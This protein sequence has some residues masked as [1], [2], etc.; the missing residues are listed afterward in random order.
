MAEQE[1]ATA[2]FSNGANA[3]TG[4]IPVS[5]DA[6]RKKMTWY[7]FM[8]TAMTEAEMVR[9]PFM[10]PLQA[11]HLHCQLGKVMKKSICSQ[12]D[13]KAKIL[14]STCCCVAPPVQFKVTQYLRTSEESV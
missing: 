1:P 11:I 4:T 8:G 14:S 13:T 5:Y 10:M 3:R 12:A 6:E 7:Y 9:C 2:T